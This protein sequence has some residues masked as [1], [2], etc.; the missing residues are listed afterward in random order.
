MY[1]R[2]YAGCQPTDDA[3]E[4]C[5]AGADEKESPAETCR[6]RVCVCREPA[7][8]PV[9]LEATFVGGGGGGGC[10]VVEDGLELRPGAELGEG[11]GGRL[12]GEGQGK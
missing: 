5:L 8:V 4:L 2:L 10:G 11:R 9:L 3:L 6:M 12:E 1:G 7:R